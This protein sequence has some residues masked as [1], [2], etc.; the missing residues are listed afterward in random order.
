MAGMCGNLEAGIN[1][2]SWPKKGINRKVIDIQQI[3]PTPS[4]EVMQL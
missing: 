3:A 1:L 4:V 2:Q